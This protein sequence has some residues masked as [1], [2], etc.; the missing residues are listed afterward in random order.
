MVNM[1]VLAVIEST[2]DRFKLLHQIDS[3][4]KWKELKL[5]HHQKRNNIRDMQLGGSRKEHEAQV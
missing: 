4:N 3:D 5:C 1:K 2:L